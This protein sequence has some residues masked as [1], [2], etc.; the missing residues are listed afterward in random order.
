M[1][2]TMNIKTELRDMDVLQATCSRLGLTCSM[3]T[4]RL[5][6]G[7]EVGMGIQ[8]KNWQYPIVVDPQTGEVRYDTYNGRW[9]NEKDLHNLEAY[10]SIEKAKLE[11]SRQ[12]YT[13][14]EI[15][16]DG[17]IELTIMVGE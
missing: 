4:H 15:D 7:P 9:G 16:T 17:Q 14:E 12:G 8:F 3:G 1:S 2:H 10:Y 13:V 6:A 5:Y 11:A